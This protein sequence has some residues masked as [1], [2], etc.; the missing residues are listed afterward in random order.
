MESPAATFTLAYVVLAV[1][2]VFPPNEF[3][4]AGLTVQ[5]LL[6]G[7]LGSEDAAFV[8]YHL[9]RGT[10]TLVA[11]ALLPLGERVAGK[12]K[13]DERAENGRRRGHWSRA[14]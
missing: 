2:F 4:L 7:W 1:C 14:S 6:G 3:H 11:H 8:Q 10:G 5:N 13:I 9:R 12:G